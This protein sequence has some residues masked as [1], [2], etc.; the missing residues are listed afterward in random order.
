MHF[1]GVLGFHDFRQQ[2]VQLLVPL[3][4]L[5]V[6]FVFVEACFGISHH[7]QGALHVVF[8]PLHFYVLFLLSLVLQV[9]HLQGDRFFIFTINFDFFAM[10]LYFIKLTF[11]SLFEI[12]LHIR[13]FTV[14]KI[15]VLFAGVPKSILTLI[16]LTAFHPTVHFT[17]F[18]KIIPLF[19]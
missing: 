9:K 4:Y 14:F 7:H 3:W 10:I 16:K 19:I 8:F 18:D 1:K 2:V 5:V 13:C 6:Y 11:Y 17:N 15:L 12:L